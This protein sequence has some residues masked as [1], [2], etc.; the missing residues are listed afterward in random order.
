MKKLFA[1]LVILF[2]VL[3]TACGAEGQTA[4]SEQA[5]SADNGCLPHEKVDPESGDCYVDIA[6]ETEAECEDIA[7]ALYDGYDVALEYWEMTAEDCLPGE[8]YD[9]D[10]AACYI[11]CE[12]DEECQVLAD[13]TYSGLDIYF[14]NSFGGHTGKPD[15]Q[16]NQ[17]GTAVDEGPPAIARYHLDADLNLEPVSIDEEETNPAY[18]NPERHNEI[19]LFTRSILPKNVLKEETSEYR[20]FTDGPDETLAYVAPLSTDSTHWLFAIDI[21]DAGTS[22]TLGQDKEFIHTI[23]HEFAHIVTLENDQ[24]PPD[25]TINPDDAEQG[26]PS[27]TESACQTYYTGEGCSLESSYINLFFNRFWADIYDEFDEVNYAE[28]EDERYD[29]L[30]AF[31]QKYEDRFVTEYAATNPGEDI[32]ESFTFFVLK[33]KPTGDSIAD[34]KVRFFYAFKPLVQMRT[35]IRS[36]LARINQN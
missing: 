33:D 8:T 36:Q 15:V 6:C 14:N 27:P 28:T 31:Y 34:Q 16:S 3:L 9:P 29:L 23:I 2:I 25:Q 10:N 19:W 17:T 7:A 12:T 1:T 13:E 5:N 11:E 22:D 30:D 24:V 26:K 32:A 21:A 4:V 35:Q 20:I 18:T